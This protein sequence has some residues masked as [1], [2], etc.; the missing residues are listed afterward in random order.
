VRPEEPDDD[1]QR[2]YGGRVPGR[3][4]VHQ[5]DGVAKRPAL[6]FSGARRGRPPRRERTMIDLSG[7]AF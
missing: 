7:T 6:L 5:H 3:L 1:P 4:V 2:G